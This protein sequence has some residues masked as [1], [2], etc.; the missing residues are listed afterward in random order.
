MYYGSEFSGRLLDMWAYHYKVQIDFSRP[1]KPTDN[2]FIETFNGSLR[3]ECLNLHWFDSL[4]EAKRE[5]EAWRRDYNESRPHMAPND[6]TPGEFVRQHSLRAYGR[7][8]MKGL[9]LTL[10]PVQETQAVQYQGFPQRPLPMLSA[11]SKRPERAHINDIDQLTQL[12][13]Y[14]LPAQPDS[15]NDR[16]QVSRDPSAL[17]DRPI[18]AASTHPPHRAFAEMPR[19]PPC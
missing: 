7:R 8:L 5:I 12:H 15:D 10:D 3:N 17:R 13:A 9:A 2:S 1:G 16:N 6:L 14:A 4:A 19:H 11:S 18:D